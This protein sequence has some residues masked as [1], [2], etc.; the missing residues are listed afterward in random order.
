MLGWVEA[1]DSSNIDYFYPVVT[2][3]NDNTKPEAD[4]M[5]AMKLE[6]LIELMCGWIEDR[7]F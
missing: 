1:K 2:W 3:R 5:C 6:H 7:Y 4:I